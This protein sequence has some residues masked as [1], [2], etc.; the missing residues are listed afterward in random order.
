M[1]VGMI[2]FSADERDGVTSAQVQALIRAGDPMYEA[3]MPVI[4]RRED[5]FWK[6]TL[7]NLARHLGVDAK[8]EMARAVVDK[9]RQWS[10]WKNIKS[11]AAMRTML[12]SLGS[13]FRAIAKPLR[14]KRA[15]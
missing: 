4:H 14:R 7:E 12:H 10:H 11:N 15:A 5:K 13:P 3:M 1:F 8:A 9:K 2:T 6:G